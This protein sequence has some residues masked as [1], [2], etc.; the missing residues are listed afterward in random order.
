MLDSLLHSAILR[1]ALGGLLAAA[2]V[3]YQAFRTWR[4]W[5]ALLEYDWSIAT[6]RWAQGAAIGAVTAAGLEG[7]LG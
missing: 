6:W 3:D 7:T 1:G 2:A 4:S 5:Q